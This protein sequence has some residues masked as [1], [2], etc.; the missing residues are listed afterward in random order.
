MKY[1]FFHSSKS[2]NC[3][4]IKTSLL[5]LFCSLSLSFLSP[6]QNWPTVGGNNQRNGLTEMTAPN[7]ISSPF[8][9]VSS[10]SSVIGNSVYTYG[11]KF[12]NTRV[13]FSP[14][15]IGKVE[16]RSLVDGSLLWEQQISD[17]SIMYSV[18]F[19]EFAVYAH[20]YK[21]DSLY[22][23][24]TVDGSVL[25]VTSEY[26]FGGK[27]GIL[28][29][30]N[31]DPIILGRR[32]DKFTGQTIWQY[33]YIAPV[34][35]DAGYA[36]FGDTYYHWKGGIT[37]P[38]TV[39]AL[40][41]ETGDFKYETVSLPGDGD[42]EIP[43]TIG[44][45][46]T[47]YIARDGGLLY[48]L[49]DNGSGINIKW[50]YTPLT[51]I[52]G[53]LASDLNGNIYLVDGSKIRKLNAEDGSVIDSS[54]VTLTAGFLNKI[55]VDAEGKVI[56]CN[57]EAGGGKYY[58]FSSDLQ[59]L[60]WELT[61]PYN[62]YCGASL[63]KEGVMV[64]AGAGTQIKAYKSNETYK[65]VADFYADTTFTVQGGS[66]NFNDQSSYQP[67][68]WLWSFPGAVPSS[69]TDQN[70][71]NIVYTSPGIYE[72]TL[73]ATNSFGSDSLNKSCYIQVEQASFVDKVNNPVEFH[74]YQNYPNP[75]N[76]TTTISWQQ[77]TDGKVKL[78]I[79]DLLGNELFTAVDE[80]FQ[81]GLHSIE[82]DASTLTSGIYFY[83]ITI[84]NYIQTRK[85]VLLK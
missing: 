38:K 71:E 7:D 21:T 35:P 36:M 78:K 75:F 72:V 67:T 83:K 14:S 57:S 1:C 34:G 63:G 52:T 33:N 85:M 59:T 45:D 44:S 16:C 64:I 19:N 62:Y 56:V 24:S 39:F 37:S 5:I 31:G 23:L 73:V 49:E 12:V 15:Y 41:A 76:P 61:V 3:L 55:T 6:A 84:E 46:G 11:N 74:L 66:I 48:A 32:L 68:S 28:F 18:G 42:Q 25:W 29:A 8:W 58:C 79:Y 82:Y 43:L 69:S 47:I 22:A 51:S 10:S 27:S 40:D 17:S 30:C 65:P 9:T 50:T 20:D 26:M 81:A 13:V 77:P 80:E 2:L 54:Q 70:P 4:P 53:S 60:I